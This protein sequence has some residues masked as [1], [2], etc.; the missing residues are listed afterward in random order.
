MNIK[1]FDSPED[2]QVRAAQAIRDCAEKSIAEHGRFMWIVT[3]GSS[4]YHVYETLAFGAPGKEFPWDKTHIFFSDERMVAPNDALSN[5]ALVQERLLQHISIPPSQVHAIQGDTTPAQQAARLYEDEIRATFTD[6]APNEFPSFDFCL[7]GMGP[8]G[9]VASLFPGQTMVEEDTA[10]AVY[11]P[12]AG[13]DPRVPRTS[14][15]LPVLN[16]SREV[17]FLAFGEAKKPVI[18]EIIANPNE[19]AKKYPAARVSPM[20]SLSWFIN[21]E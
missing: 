15:T 21:Q 6:I 1:R 19:A 17:L 11:V 12:V 20:G 8:D 2:A 4:V 14:L 16:A 18:D 7:L 9:H 13:H 3:G 10:F 5:Y